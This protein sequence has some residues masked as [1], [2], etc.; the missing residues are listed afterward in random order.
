MNTKLKSDQPMANAWKDLFSFK[1]EK[2]KYEHDAQ[3]LMFK[4]LSEVEQYQEA[5]GINRKSLAQ[6]IKTSA[7]YL[8]QLWR[9]NKP[10]NFVTLVK[11]QDALKLKFIIKAVPVNEEVRIED[12]EFFRDRIKKYHSEKGYWTFCNPAIHVDRDIYKDKFDFDIA[13]A[14]NIN[15]ESEAIPA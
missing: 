12:E 5:Q 9:G 1:S 3:I 7:S 2:E 4:F 13:K 11:M 10:L 15:Y 8:T 14:Q 6:K